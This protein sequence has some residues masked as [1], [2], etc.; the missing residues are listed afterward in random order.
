MKPARITSREVTEAL[1]PLVDDDISTVA[2]EE[3]MA[4]EVAEI[5]ALL[6]EELGD[7]AELDA[8]VEAA[9]GVF[10]A[11][12]AV[13]TFRVS[14]ELTDGVRARRAHRRADRKA[15]RALPVRL[16]VTGPVAGEAA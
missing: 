13:E 4:A 8:L 1:F 14:R 3:D 6:A 11:A 16:E 5:D 10:A 12:E 15:L 9:D 2:R 7:V